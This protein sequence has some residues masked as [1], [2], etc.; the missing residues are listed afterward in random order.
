MQ[1][2]HCDRKTEVL[3]RDAKHWTPCLR[4]LEPQVVFH[5]RLEHILLR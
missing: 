4:T 1:K 5:E 3:G 2:P